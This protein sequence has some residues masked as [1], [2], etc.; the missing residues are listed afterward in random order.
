MI[1]LLLPLL[2][3]GAAEPEVD[4]FRIESVVYESDG[5][6]SR[7]ALEKTLLWDYQRVF[8]SVYELEAYI[9]KQ[10]NIL[11][12]KKIYK[13]VLFSYEERYKDSFLTTVEVHVSL[14]ES[15]TLLPLPIYKY[16]DNL[17]MV[18]GLNIDYKNVGGTLSDFTTNAYYSEVKSE[19]TSDWMNIRAGRYLLDFRFNQLWETVK[20][21]DEDGDTNLIYDYIQST[22]RVSTK[23]PITDKLGYFARPVLRWP[24]NYNFRLNETEQEDDFYSSSGIIP[25]YNHMLQWDG[26]NWIGNLRQGLDASIENQIEYDFDDREF[27][28]WVDGIFKSYIYTPFFNYSSRISSFYYYNDFKR[29][30]A[31][32]L[33]GVLD[34]KLSGNI[35]AFWNQSLPIKVLTIPKITELQLVPFGDM[36]FVI[37]EGESL[38][39]EDIQFTAGLSLIVFPLFLPSFSLSFDYGVN[40]RDF[41]ERELRIDSILYF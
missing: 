12:N 36:G 24:Y 39:G 27:I 17:G 28:L 13:S 1:L 33:R 9:Q 30:A 3:T 31:D 22:L 14:K 23:I 38:R 2:F 5:N 26:V 15:W 37:A 40:L 32:R 20:A 6:T 18:L 16:D 7:N 29:N 21:A 34:Y 4:N 35:G 41:E 25:A 11:V 19:I 8:K 10:K